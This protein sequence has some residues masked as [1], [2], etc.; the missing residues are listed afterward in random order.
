MNMQTDAYVTKGHTHAVCEDY[1]LHGALPFPYFILAD[2]CS[3]SPHAEVAAQLLCWAAASQLAMMANTTLA[4]ATRVSLFRQAVLAQ[5]QQAAAAIGYSAP[6]LATLMVGYV[7]AGSVYVLVWGDGMVSTIDQQGHAWVETIHY[8]G[9]TPY[10]LAYENQTMPNPKK[11]VTRLNLNQALADPQVQT[12]PM[13]EPICRC[14]DVRDYRFIG[15]MSDGV[16]S[17]KSRQ[18][19][20]A[21]LDAGVLRDFLAFKNIR[22]EFIQ[23]RS[24]RVI[25]AL[26]EQGL[27]PMDDLSYAG[28]AL[29]GVA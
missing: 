17:I 10:Y 9:H 6:L 12:V 27:R 8:A 14:F 1:T 11:T 29:R 24:K 4:F 3:S 7:C 2:G 5:A 22:G 16:D 20:E 13:C 28:V 26:A 18:T 25:S 23:R 19:W 21:G 15:I